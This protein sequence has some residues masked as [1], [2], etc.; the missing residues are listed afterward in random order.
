MS[1]KLKF[2]KELYLE[3][4]GQNVLEVILVGNAILINYQRS[5]W[6]IYGFVLE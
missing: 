5:G 4:Q 1:T 2:P 3:Q 6:K